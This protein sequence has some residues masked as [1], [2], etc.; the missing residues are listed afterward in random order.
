MGP[1]SP[2]GSSK[3]VIVTCLRSP[4]AQSIW[5][6]ITGAI[7]PPLARRMEGQTF[8]T[9]CGITSL[10]TVLKDFV[11]STPDHL[12]RSVAGDDFSRTVPEHDLLVHVHGVSAVRCHPQYF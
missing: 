8:H 4:D 12:I 11:A 1:A 7:R 5:T 9:D 2:S 3:G 6:F 10:G